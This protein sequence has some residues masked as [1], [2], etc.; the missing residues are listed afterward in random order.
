MSQGDAF[1]PRRRTVLLGALALGVPLIAPARAAAQEATAEP[2][3]ERAPFRSRPDIAVEAPVLTTSRTGR[4]DGGVLLATPMEGVIVQPPEGG[5]YTVL[6]AEEPVG[7]AAI[8]DNDGGLVWWA[9]GDY[10]NLMPITYQGKPAL[11]AFTGGAFV[12]LDSSYT[13]IASFTMAGYQADMHDFQTSPDGLRVLMM[14][15]HPTTMDLSDYGGPSQAEVLSAVIQEQEASSG[16]VTFE[17][18]SLDHIPLTETQVPLNGDF[19]DYVHAN[20]L[21]YDHDGSILMSGRHTSTVYKIDTSSG[22]IVWRLGGKSGD[23][24]FT[25][26]A[27]TPSFQHDARR[28]PSGRLSLF[29]NG[30]ERDPQ[31]SRGAVYALDEENM[32]ATL[33]EDLRPAEPVFGEAMGNHQETENGNRLVS[34]GSSGQIVEFSGSDP[35]FTASF[36]QALTYRTWRADW[37]GTPATPP[38]VVCGEPDAA[39]YRDVYMSWNGAT[40]VKRWRIEARLPRRG[41]VRLTTVDKSGF[42][43][44]ARITLPRRA[45]ALRVS[46]LDADRNVLAIRMLT[47]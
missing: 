18:N 11:G 43:T 42:E 41:F 32:T 14:A 19:L 31:F 36:P 2:I 26:P 20:S 38:D 15:Y 3:A 25:D 30:N 8:Y 44:K 10:I 9:E 6:Q 33:E 16:R 23:F 29:D 22:E 27:H 46:A 39:G 37:K 4:E 45:T 13:Q 21:A 28:L 47:P 40:E 34:F 1:A 17:W 12:V 5:P 7:G 35:V 24:A